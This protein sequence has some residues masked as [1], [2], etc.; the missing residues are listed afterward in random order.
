MGTGD[1]AKI[2]YSKVFPHF[3]IPSKIIS[4]RDPRLTSKLAQDICT[5]L[6]IHQNISTTYHPQTDGQSERTNQTLEMY[7]RI[8]CN[9]QQT[10][11]AKWLP[12]AQFILNSRPSHMTKIPPFELLIG[13]T[14]KS[15]GM[16]PIT[17]PSLQ[18]R[19]KIIED[20]RKRAQEAIL[21]S[22]MLL[23]KETP[24]R[25]FKEGNQLWLDAK[26]LRTT[27][28]THKLRSKRYGPF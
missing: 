23:S 10:D 15:H 26:N 8:F 14:P 28:P 3:R 22:Q 6:G 9:E 12:L 18:E 19:K 21:H 25:P 2:Y 11:W 16:S 27:H 1:L 20:V 4:D 5:E 17:A 13:V 7:L 24:F